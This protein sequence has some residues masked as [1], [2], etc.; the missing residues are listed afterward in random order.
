[1][2]ALPVDAA[3]GRLARLDGA[4]HPASAIRAATPF[5]T[6]LTPAVTLVATVTAAFAALLR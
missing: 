5:A 6:V 3:A 4:R 1:M 2:A